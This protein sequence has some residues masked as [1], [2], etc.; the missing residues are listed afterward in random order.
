VLGILESF[1]H[2]Y[3]SDLANGRE[4]KCVKRVL[5]N[6]IIPPSTC[7]DRAIDSTMFKQL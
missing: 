2:F 4:Q 7:K 3:F 1:R 5:E 6:K